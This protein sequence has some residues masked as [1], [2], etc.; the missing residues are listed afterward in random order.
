[1]SLMNE[2]IIFPN[3]PPRITALLTIHHNDVAKI[4]VSLPQWVS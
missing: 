3:A 2:V 4:L 1:M